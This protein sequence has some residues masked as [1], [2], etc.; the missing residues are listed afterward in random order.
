M[1]HIAQL[2]QFGNEGG[3]AVRLLDAQALQSAEPER[4]APQAARHDKCLCQVGD[5]RQ[6]LVQI[7]HGGVRLAEV[8]SLRGVGGLYAQTGKQVGAVAVSLMAVLKQAGELDGR[9]R[10]AGQCQHLVP[11]RGGAPVAFHGEGDVPVRIGL[12]VD[13][14]RRAPCGLRTELFHQL[15][16]QVDVGAGNDV[17]RQVQMETVR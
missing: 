15:Q 17:I 16:G 12:Y 4:N 2:V 9:G 3:N 8:Y 11:V 14:V 7:V 13:A 6:V 5:V 1:E 10:V